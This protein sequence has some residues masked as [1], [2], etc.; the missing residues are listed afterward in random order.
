MTP[1]RIGP[2][3][4]TG[5][6]RIHSCGL[7]LGSGGVSAPVSFFPA[8]HVLCSVH[9]SNF[10]F[11]ISAVSSSRFIR[12]SCRSNAATLHASSDA[13]LWSVHR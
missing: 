5:C 8:H 1:A 6:S 13:V 10:R 12:F 9:G 3:Q 11:F 2:I 4:R 7:H